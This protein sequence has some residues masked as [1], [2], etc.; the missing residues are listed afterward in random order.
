MIEARPITVEIS[1]AMLHVTLADGRSI[2]T[3]LDWYPR[4]MHASPEQLRNYNLSAGG[5]HWEDLDEDLSIIGMLQ[6]NHS[7]S[8]KLTP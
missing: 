5:I 8:R 6:R 3:P 7:P 4:L 1:D 2:A